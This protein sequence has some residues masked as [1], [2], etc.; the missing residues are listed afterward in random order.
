MSTY[1]YWKFCHNA[2]TNSFYQILFKCKYCVSRTYKTNMRIKRSKP[3]VLRIDKVLQTYLEFEKK[4]QST[5]P[6]SNIITSKSNSI[7]G[8]C[9]WWY[10]VGVVAS[11]K[12]GRL[13]GKILVP[14]ATRFTHKIMGKMTTQSA[15]M[16]G[17]LS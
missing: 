11:L 17:N 1:E 16:E 15:K 8:S 5:R 13:S 3:K 4:C 9:F 6:H 12:S 2:F 14:D 7:F 10:S